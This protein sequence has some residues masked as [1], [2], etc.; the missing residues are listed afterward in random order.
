MGK[1]KTVKC[2]VKGSSHDIDGTQCQDYVD[3]VANNDVVVAILSD[4]LGSKPHSEIASE[5]V[6]K[7]VTAAL[8]QKFDDFSDSDSFRKWLI[9]LSRQDI[10]QSAQANSCSVEDMDCTLLFAAIRGEEMITG[11]LGD[12][13]ICLLNKNSGEL[14]CKPQKG[15]IANSTMTVFSRDA[16]DSLR[17]KRIADIKDLE[18]VILTSDG[19]ELDIYYSNSKLVRKMAGT[20]ANAVANENTEKAQEIL[21]S[22][23][24]SLQSAGADDDISIAVISRPHTIIELADDPTW[25]CACGSRNR[26]DITHCD[27][28]SADFIDVYSDMDFSVTDKVGFFRQFNGTLEEAEYIEKKMTQPSREDPRVALNKAIRNMQQEDYILSANGQYRQ[29]GKPNYLQQQYKKVQ[30]SYQQPTRSEEER[31]MPKNYQ[32]HTS[33]KGSG[34][35]SSAFFI[36]LGCFL[37]LVIGAVVASL[38][39]PR[40]EKIDYDKLARATYELYQQNPQTM[41]SSYASNDESVQKIDALQ[42]LILQYLEGSYGV[43]STSA[44]IAIDT[45]EYRKLVAQL[46]DEYGEDG[47]LTIGSYGYQKNGDGGYCIWEMFDKKNHGKGTL[48]LSDGSILIGQFVNGKKEGQFILVEA[49]GAT[50]KVMYSNDRQYGGK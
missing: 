9:D 14:F 46:I 49:N 40:A 37:C 31:P 8:F 27:N 35:N 4:G 48:L 2:L 18:A 41:T 15:G 25:L 23:I 1:W 21:E 28:C 50:K 16:V 22:R 36:I 29:G 45:T 3:I 47:Q 17:I 34:K 12:G 10:T 13:A 43:Q 33:Q 20:Y 42:A 5:C 19:L 39:I 30:E 7:T 44:P 11:Q 26:V 38:L 6:V 32:G 24:K